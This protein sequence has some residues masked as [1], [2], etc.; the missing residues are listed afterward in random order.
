MCDNSLLPQSQAAIRKLPPATIT[1]PPHKP[2][3][4]PG[5]LF[6]NYF[7]E[8]GILTPTPGRNPCPTADFDS[9][10]TQR[11]PL[12]RMPSTFTH[13]RGLHEQELIRPL[14]DLLGWADYLP[15]K[16][17]TTTKTSPII[18]SSAMPNPKTLP[19]P[20]PSPIV[21]PTP[22]LS[23]RASASICL[24][25]HRGKTSSPHGQIL[26]YLATADI[27]SDGRIRWG[28]LTNGRIWRLYDRRALPPRQRLLRSRP[29]SSFPGRRRRFP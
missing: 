13:Q 5:Q 3:T 18:C 11:S 19:P 20:N 22:W 2:F 4:M 1:P 6:T 21:T 12:S 23:P 7:L 25:T 15:S 10:R 16:A 27:N 29:S 24:S 17:V 26:R 8:E 9:F 28:I 14:F